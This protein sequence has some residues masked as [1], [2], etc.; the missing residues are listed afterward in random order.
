MLPRLARKYS[1]FPKSAL[2]QMASDV[3]SVIYPPRTTRTYECRSSHKVVPSTVGIFFPTYLLP[4]QCHFSTHC[5][6][7]FSQRQSSSLHQADQCP[8][9]DHIP[10]PTDHLASIGTS[11]LPGEWGS[12]LFKHSEDLRRNIA[13]LVVA[14]NHRRRERPAHLVKSGEIVLEVPRESNWSSDQDSI[15]SPQ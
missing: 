3:A 12:I 11:R 4:H 14:P 6:L 5:H 15:C 7:S 2:K 8:A 10:C 9:T 1:R 13:A